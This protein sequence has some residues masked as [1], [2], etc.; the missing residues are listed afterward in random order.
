MS[1]KVRPREFREGLRYL[2]AYSNKSQKLGTKD[3]TRLA[4]TSGLRATACQVIEHGSRAVA[5]G[6]GTWRRN[7]YVNARSLFHKH[8]HP[9]HYFGSLHHNLFG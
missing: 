3:L 6:C 9:R 2:K 7:Y 4:V 5:T 1:M 8:F